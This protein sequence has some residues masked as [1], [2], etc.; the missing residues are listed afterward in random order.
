LDLADI[1]YEKHTYDNNAA[2]MASKQADRMLSWVL[3][4]KLK[5]KGVTV[6]ACHPGVIRTQLLKDLGFGGGG[7]PADGAKTPLWLATSKDVEGVTGKYWDNKTEKNC[8]FRKSD[9]L[10]A[11]WNKLRTI[12]GDN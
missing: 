8:S 10:D 9:Q 11:L 5:D 4:D 12:V 6:N 3:S 2:Y 1:N 7:S